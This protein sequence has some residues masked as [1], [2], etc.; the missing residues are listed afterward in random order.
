MTVFFIAFVTVLLAELGD[1]TQLV[2]LALSTRFPPRQVLTG[3]LGAL[4]AITALA[5]LL[6]DFLAGLVPQETA[7][8]ASGLF[9]LA[10]G[11]WMALK[12]EEGDSKVQTPARGVT[13]QTFTLVFL[14]E[15]G[16]KTQL[17]AIA[18]TASYG[19]PVAVFLGAM[20]GQTVNH[21]L[22][23]F[24]GARFLGRLP[25]YSVKIASS[26]LFI[27]FGVLFLLTGLI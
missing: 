9:F 17:A 14:A 22:A 1:K 10:M 4:A 24:L 15:L 2:T 13:L 20:A 8:T 3:A 21:A 7:L 27:V 6:G 16:D 26:L 19:A 23:A 25:R 11:V 5:V 18:L 12:R